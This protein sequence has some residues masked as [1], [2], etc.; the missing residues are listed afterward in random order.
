MNKLGLIAGNGVFPLEVARTARRKGMHIVAVAHIGETNSTLAELTDEITWIRVGELERMIDAFKRAGVSRVAM[1]GGISRARL[2]DSFAPDARAVAMLTRIGRLSDDAVLRGVA[3]EIEADGMSVIDPV[4]MLENVL[5]QTGLLSGP[6]PN[7]AQ[8]N[9][10]RLAF[11]IARALGSFDVGQAVA[12]RDG[13]T[14]AVE[15]IEGTDAALRRAAALCGKG[16]VVAKAAK[17]SQDLRFDRP[18]IGPATIELLRE[19]GAAVIGIEAGTAMLL[20]R[21][22]TLEL[23]HAAGITVYGYE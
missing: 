8:L 14:A 4:P 16:L 18:A 5:A 2:A 6:A 17:P 9:D 1:A 21:A 22:R 15:A 7:P 19:I 13:V 3:G 11:E 10:L 23:A 12:V 20:E